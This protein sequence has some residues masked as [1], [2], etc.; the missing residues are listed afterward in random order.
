M[1]ATGF[2]AV[3]DKEQT[4]AQ[5]RR[6]VRRPVCPSGFQVVDD[7]CEPH[8]ELVAPASAAGQVGENSDEL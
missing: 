1:H 4:D 2:A 3:A 6:W 8:V 7:K 5:G